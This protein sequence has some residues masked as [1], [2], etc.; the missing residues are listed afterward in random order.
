M[1]DC[2]LSSLTILA[3]T[4]GRA[5]RSGRAHSGPRKAS[6]PAASQAKKPR[7]SPTDTESSGVWGS[8][9]SSG[10]GRKLEV[11]GRMYR[12]P[13]DRLRMRTGTET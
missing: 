8:V 10:D 6:L 13:A 11:A 9:F 4:P 7:P 12:R 3:R 1:L 5:Q 2:I